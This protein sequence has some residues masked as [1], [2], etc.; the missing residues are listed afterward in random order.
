[1]PWWWWASNSG[2]C[3]LIGVLLTWL[4]WKEKV[5]GQSRRLQVTI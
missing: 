2:A 1:M 3:L 4:L 5:S